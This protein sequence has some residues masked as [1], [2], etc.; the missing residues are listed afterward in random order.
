MLKVEFPIFIGPLFLAGWHEGDML[1][2]ARISLHGKHNCHV[3]IHTAVIYDIF[4][5]NDVHSGCF[6]IGTGIDQSIQ[7]NSFIAEKRLQNIVISGRNRIAFLL[8][9]NLAINSSDM[10]P[11]ESTKYWQA[12]F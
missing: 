8:I 5:Q 7:I 9:T 6:C 2:V 10:K 1:W 4:S 12:S 3:Q 11:K